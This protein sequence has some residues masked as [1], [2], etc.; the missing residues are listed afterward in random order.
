MPRTPRRTR[1]KKIEEQQHALAEKRRRLLAEE[2]AQAR[3]DDTR[4]SILIGR[5]TRARVTRGDLTRERL[6]AD[7][8]R[9]LTNAHDREFFRRVFVN[10]PEGEEH[11]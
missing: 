3:K 6:I 11:S 5:M 7:M 2:N 4:L 9:F 10:P 1:I 8:D